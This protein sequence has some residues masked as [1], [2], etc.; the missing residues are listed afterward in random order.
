MMRNKKKRN[1]SCLLKPL[2]PH[3]L[4]AKPASLSAKREFLAVGSHSN[5]KCHS[6]R[7]ISASAPAL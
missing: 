3:S 6:P 1:R 7:Q 2:S 5:K 4:W